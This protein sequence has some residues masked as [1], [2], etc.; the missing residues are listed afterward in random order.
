VIVTVGSALVGL[1]ASRLLGLDFLT[2][3]GAISGAMTSTPALGAV[4]ELSSRNE[5]LLAYT[6]VYP[7]AL[8]FITV[9]CQ[10]LFF[11][12]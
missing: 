8:I 10:I 9:V 7:V 12:L 1:L 4:S 3:L 6:A 2:V 5:A 11:L